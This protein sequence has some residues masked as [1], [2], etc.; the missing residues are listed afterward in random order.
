MSKF[1]QSLRVLLVVAVF[2]L[3]GRAHAAFDVFIQF[4]SDNGDS[5]PKVEGDS[6]DSTFKASDGWCEIKGITFGIENTLNI[7]SATTGAGAGKAKFNEIALDIGPGSLANSLFVTCA[8][9][10]HYKTVKIV[11]RKAGAAA[12]GA[13][14]G[15]NSG[16]FLEIELGLV[17]VK[18]EEFA[19]SSG[20]DLPVTKVT[21]MCGSMK[22]TYRKQD[23]N[24]K[25]LDTKGTSVSWDSTTNSP[26][27]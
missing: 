22:M 12:K 9:G 14:P 20:D 6:N 26:G 24:G 7:G 13:G 18:S 16:V 19:A 8:M 10:G 3:A 25:I 21:L 5:T 1:V 23:A 17:G 15:A 2:A 11:F 4:T 27:K